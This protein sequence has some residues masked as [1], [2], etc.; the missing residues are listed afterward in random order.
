MGMGVNNRTNTY[1]TKNITLNSENEVIK[2]K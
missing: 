2:P 1:S